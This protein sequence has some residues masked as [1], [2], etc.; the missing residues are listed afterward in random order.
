M[1]KFLEN[2]STYLSRLNESLLKIN[3]IELVKKRLTYIRWKVAENLDKLLF[4]FETN[5]KKTDANISWCS[6]EASTLS[7]LNKQ[8]KSYSKINFFK[9]T[10]VKHM[11]RELDMVVPDPSD[12]PEVV[13]IGAKFILANTGNFYSVFNSFQEYEQMLNAKKIIVI[14]GIDS[15]LALQ[16]EL[17]L[18]KQLYSIFETGNLHYQSEILSR[19]GRIRGVN[20]EISLL[21]TDL[22]R[23]RL[24]DLP[25]H[26]PLFSL[27]NFDLPPVCPQDSLSMTTDSW[28]ELNTFE[29]LLNAFMDGLNKNAHTINGNYG[30]NILNQY[31]PYD[32]DLYDQVLDVR[33]IL[34]QNDKVS[35]LNKFIDADRSALALNAKKFAD[36]EKFHKYAERNFFGLFN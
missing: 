31:L 29:Q 20:A 7:S 13:V 19:P 26:R 36:K 28:F 17:Y 1:D 10:A 33:S 24:L 30:F 9:H 3:D 27:L 32:I 8:L 16:S 21:L 4:E 22:H 23:N 2:N 6:D 12:N 18:A 14:A 35:L 15:V 25:Q 11:V 5:V 34:H